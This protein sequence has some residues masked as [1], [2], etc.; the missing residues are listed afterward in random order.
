[1]IV[2]YLII[3]YILLINEY[4]YEIFA[5]IIGIILSFKVEDLISVELKALSKLENVHL[6]QGLNY[7]ETYY[8]EVGLLLNFGG[9][10]LEIKRLVNERFSPHNPVNPSP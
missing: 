9:K 6:A 5:I 8:L 7:L 1:M 3:Y 4:R 2:W 10:S